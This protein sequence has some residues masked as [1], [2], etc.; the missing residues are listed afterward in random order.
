MN[1]ANGKKEGEIK[2][3]FIVLGNILP[4]LNE[5]KCLVT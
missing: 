2:I 3:I 4:G 1:N 5:T